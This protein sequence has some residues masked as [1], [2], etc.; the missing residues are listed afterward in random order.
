MLDDLI[1]NAPATLLQ[2]V[3]IGR[4]IKLTDAKSLQP[5][6]EKIQSLLG[7][8]IDGRLAMQY[9]VSLI[10]VDK[11][12]HIYFTFISVDISLTAVFFIH[13]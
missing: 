8:R 2:L 9:A 5:T 3:Q 4:C 1:S 7:G 12:L 6:V 10:C 13:R 11:V